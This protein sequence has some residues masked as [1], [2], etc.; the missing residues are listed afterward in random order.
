MLIISASIITLFESRPIACR[1]IFIASS[2][3]RN[4]KYIC[5]CPI[6]TIVLIIVH[7]ITAAYLSRW[8]IRNTVVICKCVVPW[9]MTVRSM[10]V[11]SM[12]VR[13]M[14]V[15]S[16]TVRT[17]SMIITPTTSLRR[18]VRVMVILTIRRNVWAYS[19]A[20]G[21]ADPIGTWDERQAT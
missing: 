19:G 4:C 16:M 10:T 1:F 2:N 17:V 18:L 13:S 5:V 20:S 8:I 21:S 12:T 7:K 15:R 6:T 9:F 14:T 3:F 11:R